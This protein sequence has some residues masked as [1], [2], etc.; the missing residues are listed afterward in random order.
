MDLW[1]ANQQAKGARITLVI[2]KR[3]PERISHLCP[4][5]PRDQRCSGNIPFKAPAQRCDKVSLIRCH[6]G[7]AQRNRI[8]FVDNRKVPVLFWQAVCRYAS[9]GKLFP[10]RCDER[11]PVALRTLPGNGHPFLTPGHF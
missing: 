10:A 3:M 8:G 9:T 1:C 7:D 6:H 5:F 11:D 2:S 4:R